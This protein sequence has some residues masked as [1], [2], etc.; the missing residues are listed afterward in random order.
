MAEKAEG[1]RK[2]HANIVFEVA[3]IAFCSIEAGM[4]CRFT[5]TAWR[6]VRPQ[7]K[8][9]RRDSSEM[10]DAVDWCRRLLLMIDGEG[11]VRKRVVEEEGVELTASDRRRR[12]L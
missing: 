6:R 11:E 9:E 7:R 3:R 8:M 12:R 10:T 1:R 5:R 2:T 4:L